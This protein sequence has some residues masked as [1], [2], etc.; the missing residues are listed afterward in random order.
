MYPYNEHVEMRDHKTHLID[1]K[2]AVE[3]NHTVSIPYKW[4][5]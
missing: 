3:N 4:Y 5:I 2:N 1:A